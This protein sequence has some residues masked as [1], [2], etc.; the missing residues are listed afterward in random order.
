MRERCRGSADQFFRGEHGSPSTVDEIAALHHPLGELVQQRLRVLQ[1]RRVE[2]FGEPVVDGC[3]QR[4]GLVL[5]PLL[6]PEVG[7]VRG[8]AELEGLRLLRAGDVDGLAEQRLGL[9]LGVVGQ[10]Q[11]AL[12]LQPE[13]LGV[14][15]GLRRSL[16]DGEPGLGEAQCLPIAQLLLF[17]RATRFAK[18]LEL[19]LAEFVRRCVEGRVDQIE[20]SRS[21]SGHLVKSRAR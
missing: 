15:E 1:V 2:A 16:G 9:R 5:F 18:R 20:A 21:Q 19:S 7:E 6:L 3:E 10:P 12:A 17:L 8:G 13:Q 4:A 11:E 14:V